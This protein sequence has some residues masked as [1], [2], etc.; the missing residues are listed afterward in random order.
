M[1]YEEAFFDVALTYGPSV[2]EQ[3][4][5]FRSLM[6]DRIGGGFCDNRLLDAFLALLEMESLSVLFSGDINQ[7]M[8]D[9]MKSLIRRAPKDYTEDEYKESLSPMLKLL[10]KEP[11]QGNRAP[12]KFK[13]PRN[14]ERKKKPRSRKPPK[15]KV[16]INAQCATLSIAPTD[17]SSVQ[18]D[19]GRRTKV[20]QIID[21][22]EDLT[23]TTVDL[24]GILEK[25][26]VGLPKK[27]YQQIDINF[28]GKRLHL[29]SGNES[30]IS[31]E[32]MCIN[33]GNGSVV[34]DVNTGQM[35]AN[36]HQGS[37]MINGSLT[38]LAYL[39]EQTDFS[40]NL[41]G[42]GTRS[43]RAVVRHGNIDVRFSEGHVSPRINH[44]FSSVQTVDGT[45]R[46]GKSNVQLA[47]SAKKGKIKVS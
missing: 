20:S 26:L 1:K 14:P 12:Q 25:V 43:V 37:F 19:L 29:S 22:H 13:K 24:Q 2:M 7:R 39:G 6:K 10:R 16:E 15:P 23:K 36:Q 11:D 47:L 3:P 5:Y 18:V 35:I 45:Y 42:Q 31:T 38:S 9:A 4:F 17:A 28:N 40:C 30:G 8:L 44:I 27:A 32:R 33:V 21:I 34:A 41:S 46:V